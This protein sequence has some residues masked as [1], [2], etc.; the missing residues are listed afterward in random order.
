MN[1]KSLPLRIILFLML[2]FLVNCGDSVNSLVGDSGST[3]VSLRPCKNNAQCNADEECKNNVCVKK[4]SKPCRNKNDCSPDQDCIGG[5]CIDLKPDGGTDGGTD[6]GDTDIIKKGKISAD[7]MTVEFGAMRF[8]EKRERTIKVRNDGNAD[9]KVLK[10]ELDANVDSSTFGFTTDFKFGS[11]LKPGDEF[12][13]KATCQ[14]NDEV[15]DSGDILISSDDPDMPILRVK[16][17]N[18]YKDKPDVVV[19]YLDKANQEVVYPGS[20]SQ[21]NEV[22]VDIGNVPLGEKK[23]QI[24]TVQNVSEESIVKISEVKYDIY[25]GNST[26]INKFNAKLLD[27]AENG[28]E[29]RLPVYLSPSDSVVLLV[30]YKADA[31]ALEDKYSVSVKTNDLDVNNDND[32]K[33]EG[34]VII[35]FKAMA[36]YKDPQLAVLDLNDKDIL[37][38]GID[39]GEVEKGIKSKKLFKICNSGGG[40]LKIDKTSA[41]VNGNFTLNPLSLEASLKYG[42]CINNIEIEFVPSVIGEVKDILK[43][44][45]NDPAKPSAELNIRGK[46]IN[47]EMR[48]NPSS[49]DFGS[50]LLNSSATPV[51]VEIKNIGDGTLLV[52]NIEFGAG[53]SKDFSLS[54]LPNSYPVKLKYNESVT[55]SVGFKPT[56][57]GA[58]SGAVIISS[59]DAENLS[60][61]I[62]LSGNGSNCDADH[63]DCNNDPTDGC[64]IDLRTDKNNC[65]GCGSVCNPSNANATCENKKCR[66]ESC[67]G[68]YQDCNNDVSDGCESDMLIDN[69]NCGGCRKICGN[70][71]SCK[72]G[73]CVCESGYLNCDNDFA[74]NGCEVDKNTDPAH[75]GDCITNCGQNSVCVS[76]FCGCQNDY[77]N[78]NN[79]L[80]DGCEVNIKINANHCG[81]CNVKCGPN[82][83]CDNGQCK[84]NFGYGNCNG[85][86]FDGCEKYLMF[87][88]NNCGECKKVCPNPPN[89]ISECN[90]GQC[91]YT[92]LSGYRD[93]DGLIDNGCE[94]ISNTDPNNC[95]TCGNKCGN[96]MDCVN[97]MCQCKSNYRD[98]NNNPADGCEVNISNDSNNCGS[99]GNKCNNNAY[100]SNSLC[101]CNTNYA[102]CNNLWTDGCEVYLPTDVYNCGTCGKNCTALSNVA[103]ASCSNSNCIINDCNPNT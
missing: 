80:D 34:L 83:F 70:K 82:A 63:A 75:C 59:S 12:E 11:T 99:C 48:V 17:K 92:C 66:I 78:C 1:N 30:E 87:D 67:K 74:T 20:G 89:A 52:N 15:P 61:Q 7:P 21:T 9:L 64:E 26:N 98:C 77:K 29:L 42:Q 25:N 81:D 86:W 44:I 27:S 54:N 88:K 65:G 100:C 55:F 22:T 57:L 96:N 36:G 40:M 46:G 32:T 18:S 45:S 10:V 91:K 84:C 94:S 85:D 13:I 53:S 56:T 5:K 79:R 93:C 51:V 2:V 69:S 35:N 103:S 76:G 16:M 37:S 90:M 43:I 31:E 39:F 3:D 62:P 33:E 14:Q 19:K 4:E 102:N 47:S 71:S 38:D 24:V 8:G 97:G 101:A 60:L 49:I 6:V 50:V 72:N 95:G 41:L 58:K 73:S 28:N 23:I 68:T